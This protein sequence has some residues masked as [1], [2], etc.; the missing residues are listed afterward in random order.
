MV[1]MLKSLHFN[2]FIGFQSSA[3]ALNSVSKG[4]SLKPIVSLVL[5][6]FLT[7]TGSMS[8]A[9]PGITDDHLNAN[10]NAADADSIQ[11]SEMKQAVKDCVE[12]QKSSADACNEQ[13]SPFAQAAMQ[14]LAGILPMLMNQS[15]GQKLDCNKASEAQLQAQQQLGQAPGCGGQGGGGQP[16]GGGGGDQGGGGGN[17]MQADC[18]GKA[19]GGQQKCEK[20][21]QM[22]DSI[23]AKKCKPTNPDYAQC[24]ADAQKAKKVAEKG[25]QANQKMGS[26]NMGQLMQALSQV[27]CAAQKKAEQCQKDVC[28]APGQKKYDP[29][30]PAVVAGAAQ[31]GSTK[32][33]TDDEGCLVDC[34]MIM[35]GPPAEDKKY[36]EWSAKNAQRYAKFRPM[37]ECQTN[38]G[39]PNCG[40]G[41]NQQSEVTSRTPKEKDMKRLG[42]EDT[43]EGNPTDRT[44]GGYEPSSGGSASKASL[45]M[46]GGGGAG[47]SPSSG[48]DRAKDQRRMGA[49]KPIEV[50]AGYEGGSGSSSRSMGSSAS[51]S[52]LG[53][54][55]RYLPGQKKPAS[56]SSL[57]TQ[58]TG[59]GG[60][61]IWEKVS[62]AYRLKAP[63]LNR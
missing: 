29:N 18:G 40:N 61:S 62:D 12:A 6:F 28:S 22:I 9:S 39:N 15:K 53:K 55:S 19:G 17:N 3:F 58:I 44:P 38:P 2:A 42:V 51:D 45:G 48:T 36:P 21:K 13:T 59:A 10:S 63:S 30:D 41:S 27:L 14:A 8:L 32:I 16:G 1:R 23:K 26:V 5:S 54:Y 57:G 20:A 50:T 24:E 47:L 33:L 31:G 49:P 56:D 43:N 46:G 11:D 60:K 34:A 37:C 35:S 25:Q 52:P 4:H 7:F